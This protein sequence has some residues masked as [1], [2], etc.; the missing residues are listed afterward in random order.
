MM[1]APGSAA[2]GA[3]SV[4]AAP[5]PPIVDAFFAEFHKQPFQLMFHLPT[6]DHGHVEVHGIQGEYLTKKGL[7]KPNA[8]LRKQKL[9]VGNIGCCNRT[10]FW[11][12]TVLVPP[13]KR[14]HSNPKADLAFLVKFY[15]GCLKWYREESISIETSKF[16]EESYLQV[17]DARPELRDEEQRFI[18]AERH[19]T[20]Q[21]YWKFKQ[22]QLASVADPTFFDN[23]NPLSQCCLTKILANSYVFEAPGINNLKT[24]LYTIKTPD[25]TAIHPLLPKNSRCFKLGQCCSCDIFGCCGELRAFKIRCGCCGDFEHRYPVYDMKEEAILEREPC[26]FITVRGRASWCGN[27]PS[28]GPN[29]LAVTTEMPKRVTDVGAKVLV[30]MSMDLGLAYLKPW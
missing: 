23:F 11:P 19:G 3:P 18:A 20:G 5:V 30:A 17:K 27:V 9:L 1:E 15:G 22:V 25:G 26:S 21:T 10:M 12:E 29:A 2:S 14:G 8:E 6:C 13:E 4:P 16:T 7:L 24:E 28:A